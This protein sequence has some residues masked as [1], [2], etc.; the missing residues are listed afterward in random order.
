[1]RDRADIHANLLQRCVCTD[2][3]HL[4]LWFL[5]DKRIKKK[6]ERLITGNGML[7]H[8]TDR[9]VRDHTAT[10]RC[11]C[12][13]HSTQQCQSVVGSLDRSATTLISTTAQKAD[14]SPL[15]HKRIITVP[16]VHAKYHAMKIFAINS[17]QKQRKRYDL[18][19][20]YTSTLLFSCYF[21]Q[22]TQ[23]FRRF[24]TTS[25]Y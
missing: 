3:G 6:V 20:N 7:Q 5:D 24:T 16:S 15:I 13:S 18:R 14:C 25:Q 2:Y 23:H 21:E 8:T 11:P 17:M 9:T 19:K 10:T 12:C 4:R 22:A 1:M